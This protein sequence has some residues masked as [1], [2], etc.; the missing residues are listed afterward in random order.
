[1]GFWE[2]RDIWLLIAA[3]R[4]PKGPYILWPKY[5]K[6]GPMGGWYEDAATPLQLRSQPESAIIQGSEHLEILFLGP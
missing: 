1:M 5:T 3:L 6:D 4:S 2:K